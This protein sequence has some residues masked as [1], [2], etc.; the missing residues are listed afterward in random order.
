MKQ[1]TIDLPN[2]LHQ[3]IVEQ[4]ALRGTTAVELVSLWLWQ[5]ERAKR[6]ELQQQMSQAREETANHG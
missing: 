4:A 5:V 3:R 1:L 6:I 2:E